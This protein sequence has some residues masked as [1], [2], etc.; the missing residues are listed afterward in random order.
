MILKYVGNYVGK[1]FDELPAAIRD[2]C[3]ALSRDVCNKFD[4]FLLINN[5]E[6]N[7]N[8]GNLFNCIA[9][10]NDERPSH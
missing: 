1:L 5:N 3:D 8:D 6:L 10:L 2:G 7:A 9:H 4:L